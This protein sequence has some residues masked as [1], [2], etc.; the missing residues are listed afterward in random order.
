MQLVATPDTDCYFWFW[1]G[2]HY[3]ISVSYMSVELVQILPQLL[4]LVMFIQIFTQVRFAEN[5][6]SWQ[7]EDASF[8]A[9]F[10]SLQLCKSLTWPFYNTLSWVR[11]QLLKWVTPSPSLT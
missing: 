9:E 2:T 10:T 11:H 4:I 6:R 3:S 1:P 7:W 5:K 8:F